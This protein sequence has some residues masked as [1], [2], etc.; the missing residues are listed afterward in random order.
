MMPEEIA[1]RQF[2]S[3]AMVDAQKIKNGRLKPEDWK[4]IVAAAGTLSEKPIGW[5]KKAGLTVTQIKA[6]CRRFQ[7]E[8]GLGLVIIDQLDKIAERPFPGEKRTDTIGRT[9]RALK[10]MAMDLQVPVI[11]LVQLLDKEVSKRAVPRPGPGDVRDSSFPEQDADIMLY[12]WRP[13]FYWPDKQQYKNRAE[14]IV[15]R[16]RSGPTGSIWVTWMPEYV[17]FANLPWEQWPKG[18]IS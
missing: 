7:A 17:A 14:I 1:D 13:S 15:G 2:S 5:V 10:L 8:H 12:M 11:C 3:A 4:K 9:T 16:Q 6:I 18:E